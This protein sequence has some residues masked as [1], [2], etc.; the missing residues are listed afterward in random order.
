MKKNEQYYKTLFEEKEKSKKKSKIIA[1]YLI[2]DLVT[3][4]LFGIM[5][6]V[7]A[8]NIYLMSN[9]HMALESDLSLS[10]LFGNFFVFV[11]IIVLFISVIIDQREKF[12]EEKKQWETS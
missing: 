7:V 9:V 10:L 8:V 11:M 4:I 2:T 12:N 6:V 3:Y 1:T 5:S